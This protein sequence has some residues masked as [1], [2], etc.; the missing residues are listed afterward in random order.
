MPDVFAMVRTVLYPSGDPVVGCRVS[1]HA[2]SDGAMLG[3]AASGSDGRAFLGNQ[4]AGTYELRI[5]PQQGWRVERPLQQAVVAG[6]G[7]NMFDV[8]VFRPGR[9]SASDPRYCRCGG[10]FAD[11]FGHP[12]KK[13]PL[14]FSDAGPIPQLL[15]DQDIARAVSVRSYTIVTDAD[16]YCEI[17]LLRGADYDVILPGY[18]NAPITVRVPDLAQS[19]LPDMLFPVVELLDWNLDPVEIQLSLSADHAGVH[20]PCTTVMRSGLRQDGAIDVT[21]DPLDATVVHV[22]TE[23][24]GVLLMPQ[25]TG[26][27]TIPVALREPEEGKGIQCSPPRTAARGT[28]QVTVVV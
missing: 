16:G 23:P 19:S 24:G 10:S 8:A 9:T 15:I 12:A 14:I 25:Q 6:S 20:L 4:S 18:E 2:V 7:V 28:L 26:T 11:A 17:D 27:T 1:L 3:E 21:L 5:T 13:L 22:S